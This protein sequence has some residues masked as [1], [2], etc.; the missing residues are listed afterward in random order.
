MYKM[1]C[2]PESSYACIRQQVQESAY[3][4]FA[5]LHWDTPKNCQ[6]GDLKGSID[7]LG[8]TYLNPL[9]FAASQEHKNG[10]CP[11]LQP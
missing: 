8:N 5:E 11:L 2:L 6:L 1:L 3:K 10:L 7:Q 9:N 4:H